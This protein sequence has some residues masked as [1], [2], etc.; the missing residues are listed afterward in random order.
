LIGLKLA[1]KA[2]GKPREIKTEFYVSLNNLPN[3]LHLL[4]SIVFIHQIRKAWLKITFTA[5]RTGIG[6]WSLAT[7]AKGAATSW[8]NCTFIHRRIQRGSSDHNPAAAPDI[9]GN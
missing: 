4:T 1:K 5:F 3:I 7:E 9:I 6:A 8:A 2:G